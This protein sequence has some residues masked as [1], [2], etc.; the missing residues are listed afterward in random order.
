MHGTI[1]PIETKSYKEYKPTESRASSLTPKSGINMAM[2]DKHSHWH[3]DSFSTNL[4]S[5]H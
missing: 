5:A 3:P 1:G 4:S 2:T